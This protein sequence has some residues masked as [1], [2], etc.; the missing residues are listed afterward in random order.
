M[1]L[2]E[3]RPEWRPIKAWIFDLDNTLISNPLD[4]DEIRRA[5]RMPSEGGDILG[6][7]RA[8]TPTAQLE[9]NQVLEDIEAAASARSEALPGAVKLLRYLASQADVR[10]GVLSRNHQK[11]MEIGLNAAGMAGVFNREY[12]LSREHCPPKP[13]PAGI[14]Q[15][16]TA[17]NIKPEE[18]VMVGDFHHDLYAGRNAGVKTILVR[19]EPEWPDA[20]DFHCT[21]LSELFV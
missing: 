8:M 15:L 11:A 3:L 18:A 21:C 6:F 20:W 1:P 16:L 5:L 19:D 10:L 14:N 2:S 13:D 17:W 7:I 12:I 4:F 9:A